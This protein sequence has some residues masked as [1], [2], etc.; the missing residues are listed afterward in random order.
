ME[1]WP[2]TLI[3]RPFV[4]HTNLTQYASLGLDASVHSHGILQN[5]K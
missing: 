2:N 4:D 5:I 3:L 1:Q